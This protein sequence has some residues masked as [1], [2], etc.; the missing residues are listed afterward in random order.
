[1]LFVSPVFLFGFLPLTLV[2]YFLGPKSLR[3]L[4]LLVASLIFY[5]WGEQ[6]YVL[7]MIASIIFNW[8]IGVRVDRSEH[9]R[10]AWLSFG[11]LGN[12]LSLVF[13]KYANFIWDNVSSVF[14]LFGQSLTPIEHIHLPIGISFFTF[15][16]ISY[17]VDVYRGQAEV[18]KNPFKLGL[19]IALFPQ[20]IAGPIVRYASIAESIDRRSITLDDFSAGSRRF[21]YGLAKKM[22]LANPLGELTDTIFALPHHE[23]TTPLAWLGVIAYTLQG[24]L[25][26][27]AYSDMAIGL[28][29][30][31]GFRFLENF[32]YPY[33]AQSM[34]EFWRRWH[35]SLG[36]WFRDYIYFPIGGSRVSPMRVKM[37]LMIV[38]LFTGIWHGAAW[39]FIIWGIYH[40]VFLVMERDHIGKTIDALPRVLRHSYALMVIFI[41]KVLFRSENISFAGSYIMRLFDPTHLWIPERF[42]ALHVKN[43][44]LLALALGTLISIP[45]FPWLKQKVAGMSERVKW[46]TLMPETVLLGTLFVMSAAKAASSSYNPFIYFRF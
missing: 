21:V 24:Y 13:F 42:W 16:A 5:A 3:N 11:I 34:R 6:Q 27:S 10:L 17:I 22:M 4:V 1:M 43:E 38:F 45:I 28:G 7:L 39:N 29:R 33:I 2:L 20:L 32:N 36:G 46:A 35:M 25:D 15:Q 37:N 30:M 8:L 14:G 31:F 41:G 40:G 44:A 9:R 26:F 23:L 12:V 19:Y 18:Q